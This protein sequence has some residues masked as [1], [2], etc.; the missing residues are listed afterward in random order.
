VEFV[1]STA[2]IKLNSLI[3]D[4]GT[5]THFYDYGDKMVF[6]GFSP[7]VVVWRFEKNNFSRLTNTFNGVKKFNNFNGQLI[8]SDNEYSTDFND[9][10]FV[11]VGGVSGLDKIFS[12]EEGNEEFVCSYTRTNGHLRKMFYNFRSE[13]LEKHKDLLLTRQM[14]QFNETDWWK[15]GRDFYHSDKDRIYVNCKTRVNNPFFTNEC[16]NYDGSV[17]AI[18]PK[19][20]DI[21]IKKAVTELNN[22][23][24]EDLGFKIGGRYVFS[25]KSLSNIKLSDDFY[26]KIKKNT[27]F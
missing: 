15:W 6:P 4:I 11:K 3:Y 1:K 17:L 23:K 5:I 26:D 8:F 16:K 9:L 19:K 24:W 22:I 20:D 12:S 27:Q 10:F 14:K 2:S 21:D 13:Y 7:N 18:F 25:Q